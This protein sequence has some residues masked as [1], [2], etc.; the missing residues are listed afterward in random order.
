MF[1]KNC[2]A[3]IFSAC[4]PSAAQDFLFLTAL[5]P[6]D[7]SAIRFSIKF[8]F[9]I[10]FNKAFCVKLYFDMFWICGLD[11][12]AEP[13]RR[14]YLFIYLFDLLQIHKH[15]EQTIRKKIARN[16][17]QKVDSIH[18]LWWRALKW[19]H[20]IPPGNYIFPD[21]LQAAMSVFGMISG[22][23]LGLFI[24]GLFYP[25]ANNKVTPTN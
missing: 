1:R 2:R 14:I 8:D 17:S 22:P 15:L 3:N 21:L 25:C 23:V 7:K 10:K 11:F 5:H 6:F 9:Q 20:H 12:V 4:L 13:L 18:R 16:C 24:L 19:H